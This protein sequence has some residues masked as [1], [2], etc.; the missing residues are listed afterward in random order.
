VHYHQAVDRFSSHVKY[1]GM[2]LVYTMYWSTNKWFYSSRA[3]V[4][5]PGT[6]EVQYIFHWCSDCKSLSVKSHNSL[7]YS[8]AARYGGDACVHDVVGV[9][10]NH[11]SRY[12]M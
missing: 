9:E 12:A 4:L 10:P 6:H 5:V 2:N 11:R 7:L 1:T 3:S 8:T